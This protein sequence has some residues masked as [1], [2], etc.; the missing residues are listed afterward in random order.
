MDDEAG[1][2]QNTGVSCSGGLKL[3]LLTTL[4]GNTLGEASSLWQ[5]VA[6]VRQNMRPVIRLAGQEISFF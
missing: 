4:S 5:D 6:V 2:G 3:P 1:R